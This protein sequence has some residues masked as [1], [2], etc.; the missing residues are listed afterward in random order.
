[1]MY[2]EL[3]DWFHLLTAPA[4]YA[5]E[6]ALYV[7]VLVAH[8]ERGIGSVL[9]LGSGGGNTASHLSKQFEMTLCDRSAPMLAQSRRI[10]PRCR[11]VEGDMRTVD[12]DQVFDAVFLHDAVM[13]MTTEQDLAAALRTMAR[14]CRPGG[15]ALVVPDCTTENFEEDVHH[16]GH[17]SGDRSL[18]YLQ[19]QW[20]PDPSDHVYS[21]DFSIMTREGTAAVRTYED[22]H[23]FGLFSTDHWVQ[24]L[25]SAGFEPGVVPALAYDGGP[26]EPVMFVG[27]KPE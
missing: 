15:V 8:A 17:D 19:W 21:V 25:R 27:V 16:G 22:H 1:M 26:R 20:D 14:H 4:D 11:H 5:E 23:E 7:E 24:A 9:E 10:N 2:G 12:L 6:A 3:A 18:R 13:Y